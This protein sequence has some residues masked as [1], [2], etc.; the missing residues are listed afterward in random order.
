MD[1]GKFYFWIKWIM[2]NFTSEKKKEEN[3]RHI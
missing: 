3:F 2:G 1:N